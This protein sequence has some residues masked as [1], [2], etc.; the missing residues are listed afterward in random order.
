MVVHPP[1]AIFWVYLCFVLTL[2]VV[3]LSTFVQLSSVVNSSLVITF[4]VGW[5]KS[6]SLWWVVVVCKPI[7]VL[8]FGFDQVEQYRR[9]MI[10]GVIEGSQIY[11]LMWHLHKN[12]CLLCA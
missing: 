1:S 12:V 8:S 3:R 2:P 5:N 9:R 7:L 10:I 11:I 4:Y 6:T